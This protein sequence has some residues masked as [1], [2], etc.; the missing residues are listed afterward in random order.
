VKEIADSA[1][2]ADTPRLKGT[3]V[4][5]LT[6]VWYSLQPYTELQVPPSV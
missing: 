6:P 4:A 3:V 1:H 2:G 5:K